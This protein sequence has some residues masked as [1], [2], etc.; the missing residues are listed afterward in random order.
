VL[1]LGTWHQFLQ[2]RGRGRKLLNRRLDWGCKV[3]RFK[4]NVSRLRLQRFN[5]ERWVRGQ[6]RSQEPFELIDASYEFC[7]QLLRFVRA[8]LGVKA[9]MLFFVIYAL[10]GGRFLTPLALTLKRACCT[11]GLAPTALRFSLHLD[12]NT[13]AC[14]R[15]TILLVGTWGA[16]DGVGFAFAASFCRTELSEWFGSGDMA[17]RKT[18]QR[19]AVALLAALAV[20]AFESS[21]RTPSPGIRHALRPSRRIHVLQLLVSQDLFEAANSCRH[22]GRPAES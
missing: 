17:H 20:A 12:P 16:A 7:G 5:R 8:L 3:T 11:L 21:P 1:R 10:T 13:P 4:R 6:A 14:H 15:S 22:P 18:M 19:R 2:A 9:L